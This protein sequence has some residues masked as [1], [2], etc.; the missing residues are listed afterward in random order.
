MENAFP[1]ARFLSPSDA[2]SCIINFKIILIATTM[3][4]SWKGQGNPDEFAVA[5]DETLGDFCS[6]QMNLSFDVWESVPNKND[7]DVN[8][9]LWKNAPLFLKKK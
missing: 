3:F 6:S 9:R 7:Y 5:L 8:D 4:R 2:V 1:V